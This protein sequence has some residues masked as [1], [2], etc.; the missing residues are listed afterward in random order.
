MANVK[1][2]VEVCHYDDRGDP[3][4][5]NTY[6]PELVFGEQRFLPDFREFPNGCMSKEKANSLANRIASQFGI[7]AK[8]R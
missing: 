2:Y 4:P 5:P 6:R 1:P 7:E 3:G 8:L